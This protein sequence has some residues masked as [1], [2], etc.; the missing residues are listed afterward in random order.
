MP[1][2]TFN[3]QL[4]SKCEHGNEK[5]GSAE[6]EVGTER[7]HQR[8]WVLASLGDTESGSASGGKERGSGK[9]DR[10]SNTFVSFLPAR[11][12]QPGWT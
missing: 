10:V 9:R 11:L 12:E 7:A 2:P 8:L 5:L 4:A 3:T 6:P 1:A